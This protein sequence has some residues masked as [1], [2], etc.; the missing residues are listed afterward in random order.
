MKEKRVLKFNHLISNGTVHENYKDFESSV[1]AEVYRSATSI[2]EKIVLRNIEWM[3]QKKNLRCEDFERSNVISFI[4]RRGTGKTSALISFNDALNLY[5][6][7]VEYQSQMPLQFEHQQSMSN[8]RFYSLKCIDTSILEESENIFILI[9]A[10]MFSRI[11][12]YEKQVNQRINEYDQRNLMKKFEEIYEDFVSINSGIEKMEGYSSYEKLRNAASSQRIR[13]NFEELVKIYLNIIDSEDMNNSVDGYIHCRYKFLV[14]LL[15]DID[16]ARQKKENGNTNWGVYKIMNTIYKYLTVPGVIVLS[17]YDYENLYQRCE[18]F[19]DEENGKRGNSREAANQLAEKIFPISTRI[20]MPSWRKDDLRSKN[21]IKI[22]LEGSDDFVLKTYRERMKIDTFQ[23]KDFIFA[24]LYEKTGVCFDY[25]RHSRHFFEP[26]TIRSLYNTVDFLKNLKTYDHKIS[27]EKEFE[28]FQHNIGKLKED[29]Y[30]R[31]KEEILIE[32]NYERGLFNEWIESSAVDRS[33]EIVRKLS[34]TTVPLGLDVKQS[35]LEAKYDYDKRAIDISALRTDPVYDNSNVKYSYAELIH[36]IYHMTRSTKPYSMKLVSCIL[37]SFTLHLTDIYKIY[38]WEK[39]KIPKD[40]YI[41]FYRNNKQINSTDTYK[42]LFDKQATYFDIL[43]TIAGEAICGKWSQYFFPLVKPKRGDIEETYWRYNRYK[44]QIVSYIRQISEKFYIPTESDGERELDGLKIKRFLFLSMQNMDCLLWTKEQIIW[45]ITVRP[46]KLTINCDAK[47]DHDLTG[48]LRY[49]FGY[50][51]FLS[52]M[53]NILLESLESTVLPQQDVKE[54][55]EYKDE[56]IQEIKKQFDILWNEYYEWDHQ[57]GNMMVP[58][59]NL[60]ITYNMIKKLYQRYEENGLRSIDII[61]D[62]D[63][64]PFLEEYINM[65]DNFKECLSEI[66]KAYKLES[67]ESF[68]N[69]FTQCPY[70]KMVKELEA[71]HDS[72]I[73]V[74]NYFGNKAFDMIGDLKEI[75]AP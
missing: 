42:E 25:D 3:D 52:K 49:T 36:S 8:V 31:Y 15:D 35:Y 41:D 20:Y 69:I 68:G 43:N 27:D 40:I 54:V 65:L 19:F 24:L 74:S 34:Q 13:E 63:Q 10:N 6:R 18:D 45:D 7:N 30:F 1:Y 44:P 73:A 26:D 38:L 46:F 16:L 70:Y 71:D 57:Y 53:E 50:K 58:F 67:E 4:G 14:I 59:Y 32:N 17:A 23:I 75:E 51:N 72:R 21:E 66:D 5:M 29:C 2:T 56:V 9:L 55:K 28:K 64:T 61:M 12:S 47:S 48:F 39:R 11:Q 22:S 62:D 60:D 33:K 37:Y